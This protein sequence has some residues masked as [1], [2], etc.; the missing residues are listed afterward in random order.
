[1]E[2]YVKDQ[3]ILFTSNF[4]C[5]LLHNSVIRERNKELIFINEKFTLKSNPHHALI[6]VMINI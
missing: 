4:I 1:M 6:F 5:F 2:Q 3:E